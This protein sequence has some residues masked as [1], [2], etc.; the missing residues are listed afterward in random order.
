[1]GMVIN[2]ELSWETGPEK[3]LLR[4]GILLGFRV[5]MLERYPKQIY[6][7][8]PYFGQESFITYVFPITYMSWTLISIANSSWTA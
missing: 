8:L 4:H 2:D 6:S 1:M 5:G 3:E 7:T